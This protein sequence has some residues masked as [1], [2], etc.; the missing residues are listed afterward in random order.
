MYRKLAQADELRRLGELRK[1][2]RDRFGPLPEKA[3]LALK[4]ADLKIA[5]AARG[6]AMIEAKEDKLM[7]TAQQRLCHG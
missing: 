7:L 5:A 4:V 2:W 3:E 6:V 1:E